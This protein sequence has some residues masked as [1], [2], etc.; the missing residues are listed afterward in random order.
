VGEVDA[1]PFLLC[2]PAGNTRLL[3]TQWHPLARE[4]GIRIITID[5]PGS[6]GTAGGTEG[7]GRVKLEE[8]VR[9]GCLMMETVLE[10]EKI[11][12]GKCRLIS[13]SNGI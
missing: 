2:G 8:R 10:K 4:K 3:P 6:G 5:R 13:I 7:V 11:E 12:L 9:I 1:P